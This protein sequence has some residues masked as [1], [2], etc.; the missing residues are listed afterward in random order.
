MMFN[1]FNKFIIFNLDSWVP[2]KGKYIFTLQ[3]KSCTVNVD[4]LT[5]EVR[6]TDKESIYFNLDN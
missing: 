2:E 3:K 5:F 6:A 4:F 1:T